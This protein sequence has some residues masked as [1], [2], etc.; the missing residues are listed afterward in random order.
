MRRVEEAVEGELAGGAAVRADG[1]QTLAGGRGRGL[2]H[3]RAVNLPRLNIITKYFFNNNDVLKTISTFRIPSL[4]IFF[5]YIC[6]ALP[7]SQFETALIYEQEELVNN[8]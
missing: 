8:I 3:R 4:L 7:S 5:I 2:A 1:G 6:F